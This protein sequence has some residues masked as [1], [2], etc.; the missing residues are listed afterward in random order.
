MYEINKRG[1]LKLSRIFIFR[2]LI[3]LPSFEV[4]SP[5]SSFWPKPDQHHWFKLRSEGESEE[6]AGFLNEE[7]TGGILFTSDTQE[8]K[9]TP[10]YS[11]TDLVMCFGK[12]GLPVFW[13]EN[14]LCLV[15]NTVNV[16]SYRFN[17][18]HKK[19]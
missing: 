1:P 7:S 13:E 3:N 14:V 10:S 19:T 5:G 16:Q 18:I 9:V 4:Q 11:R 8:I 6:D 15:T 17:K 2:I 12:E